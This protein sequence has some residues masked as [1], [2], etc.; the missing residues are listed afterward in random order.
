M[1]KLRQALER[2]EE[3]KHK[4]KVFSFR[5]NK[6][7]AEKNQHLEEKG[8]VFSFYNK[9]EA[10]TL[11][12][13]LKV[14]NNERQFTHLNPNQHEVGI[15]FKG[16]FSTEIEPKITTEEEKNES[17]EDYAR[18][19]NGGSPPVTRTAGN[20]FLKNKK[21]R[22]FGKKLKPNY[23]RN[24]QSFQ[25]QTNPPSS[26]FKKRFNSPYGLRSGHK[27]TRKTNFK[28]Q[29]NSSAKRNRFKNS[30]AKRYHQNQNITSSPFRK[31]KNPYISKNQEPVNDLE[32]TEADKKAE[33]N[34]A[35]I[36]YLL[37]RRFNDTKYKQFFMD[38]IELLIYKH[39]IKDP[40]ILGILGNMDM[41]FEMTDLVPQ[42]SEE[43]SSGFVPSF[44]IQSK[45]ERKIRK[46]LTRENM[47]NLEQVLLLFRGDQLFAPLIRLSKKTLI[48][49]RRNFFV[50]FRFYA[51]LAPFRRLHRTVQERVRKNKRDAFYKMLFYLKPN[52]RL[53]LLMFIISKVKQRHVMDAYRKIAGVYWE[54][55]HARSIEANELERLKKRKKQRGGDSEDGD[56]DLERDK[57]NQR[58]GSLRGKKA[59]DLMRNFIDQM[60]Q[61]GEPIFDN[62]ENQGSGSDNEGQTPRFMSQNQNQTDQFGDELLE[63]IRRQEK[64]KKMKTRNKNKKDDY[65]EYYDS[66]LN[67]SKGKPSNIED[68]LEEIKSNFQKKRLGFKEDNENCKIIKYFLK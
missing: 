31:N 18:R 51:K 2:E 68:N 59:T 37:S 19:K 15:Q 4:K 65:F 52:L 20:V 43:E 49:H 32:Q 64:N 17:L 10:E 28:K 14:N 44:K 67:V 3:E 66:S 50:A 21:I 54:K 12:P 23:H 33:Q 63:K 30:S 41:R 48:S 61:R 38:Q 46:G 60:N 45:M 42:E 8:R 55:W 1:R 29:T 24:E 53:L 11:S 7:K 34:V 35:R 56:L 22:N 57:Q 13:E 25:S 40:K 16:S 47:A 26:A 9:Q 62:L 27:F 5:N 6:I 36:F 39:K 58:L